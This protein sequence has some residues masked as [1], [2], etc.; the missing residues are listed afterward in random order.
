MDDARHRAHCGAPN[1]P[2]LE[3]LRAL[4]G[5]GA[6]LWLRVPVI[7]GLNDDAENL[8]ALARL[9][10]ATPG[11]EQVN[12]LPY[13]STGVVKA[14]RLDRVAQ[15]EAHPRPEPG[16]IERAAGWF[17]AAGLRVVAGG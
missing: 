10:A 6:R 17:R 5:A 16:D 7:P 11:V 4:A 14:R 15:A 8:T 1:G 2:I 9:A 3:N 13:H 12:L